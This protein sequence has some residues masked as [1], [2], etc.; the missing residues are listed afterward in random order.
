MINKRIIIQIKSSN[1]NNI[2]KNKLMNNFIKYLSKKKT[3]K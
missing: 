3:E 2:V 1:N